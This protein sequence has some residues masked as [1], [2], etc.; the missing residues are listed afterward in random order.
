MRGA[1]S[2][3][4]DG[5]NFLLAP[6]RV[7]D[8]TDE[9]G[10]L[11]GKILADLGADVVQIEPPGGNPARNIGPFYGDDPQP[12]KSLF[13]WAYAAN[14]RSITLDLD[15]KDGQALLKKMVAEADFLVESFAP[16][17]LDT[18]GLG[19][20][21][22]AEIN[23][24]LVMVSITP[25]GQ[26]GPY[27][28]YQA[29]D[30][31]GMALGGFMYLTGDDDRAPIRISFPH[32][33][34]H[35]GAA[36]ATAAMLAHTYRITSGQGQYVDVSCQQAVAKTLAH[37]PQIW[38]IE[39]AILKRMGVYR[40][41]SGENRVRINWPCKDGYVNYMV[42]GG[43]VAYS[44]RALLEWMK[45][46]SF[47]TADLDAIDWEKMGYGAITP[48]LMSQLG[49]PLGDFFKGH[50]R[51]ELVQGSLD[52]RILLFPVA[53]PSALQDHSQLEARGY[54]KELE[55]PE[56]GAT[57]QYPG[58]FVKSGDGEDIAGIYRRPPLIGEH[59][60]VIFQGELGITGSELE[61]LKR[62]GVI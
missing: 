59:N 13:W 33:Y 46:D 34:L 50:T 1:Q 22:L 10:L 39:G 49:E 28:N 43:S 24:K 25:F 45:E 14:K 53:T 27:S 40:Q 32:F 55:H 36:G 18:L 62:S 19:Y 52:R 48:E 58:A 54:F 5:I 9:R 11:A 12:E 61:S 47:D 42:Q 3:V 26:D 7:L 37:A 38:D 23:P 16:G 2:G 56:L 6:Y 21:V 8:L 17:Y 4:P 30:I 29:T 41:T 51:A 15:Q 35:G 31:V 20:D 44:T 57:V 60:T